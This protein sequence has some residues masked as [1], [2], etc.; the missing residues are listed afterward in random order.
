MFDRLLRSKLRRVNGRASGPGRPNG[1]RRGPDVIVFGQ[2]ARDLV[3]VVDTMPGARQAAL[4]VSVIPACSAAP[5][6]MSQARPA[7]SS[8]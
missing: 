8:R 3:L 2:I 6:N 1:A 5:R 4:T 7:S